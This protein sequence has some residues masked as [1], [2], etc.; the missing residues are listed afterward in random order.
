MGT[1]LAAADQVGALLERHLD[2]RV[3]GTNA[4]AS[5]ELQR[6]SLVKGQGDRLGLDLGN[7]LG[8]DGGAVILGVHDGFLAAR[9]NKSHPEQEFRTGMIIVQANSVRG[10]WSILDEVGKSGSL[11]LLLQR[12]P[13]KENWDAEILSLGQALQ[14]TQSVPLRLRFSTPGSD[15]ET[16]VSLPAVRAGECGTTQCAVCLEDLEPD[17]PLV[18]LPCAHAF[19]SL[20]AARWLSSSSHHTCPLCVRPV[21]GER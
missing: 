4:A 12:T 9:W 20:C 19:H 3:A 13:P 18:Q 14:S 8:A 10:Y 17:D 2:V 5:N 6:V 21:C 11:E 7:A 1:A 15:N 16:F